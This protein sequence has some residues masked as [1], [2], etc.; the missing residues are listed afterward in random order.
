MHAKLVST[1]LELLAL[2]PLTEEAG[3]E[4]CTQALAILSALELERKP[5]FSTH[6]VILR[7]LERWRSAT[8]APRILREVQG[9]LQQRARPA[10]RTAF[11]E[12][13][14]AVREQMKKVEMQEALDLLEEHG[15]APLAAR[16][17]VS[18]CLRPLFS[19]LPRRQSLPVSTSRRWLM[20]NGQWAREATWQPM[21]RRKLRAQHFASLLVRGHQEVE[22]S[23]SWQCSAWTQFQVFVPLPE[24][25]VQRRGRFRRCRGRSMGAKGSATIASQD[26]ENYELD[27]EFVSPGF[28]QSA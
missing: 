6:Q 26:F 28:V 22:E 9:F 17:A 8:H 1:A 3:Q 7:I 14:S 10:T 20:E 5:S 21:S 25:G 27:S 13:V 11:D 19:T 12:K 18:R 16:A 2:G 4:A 15:A 23:E 24:G